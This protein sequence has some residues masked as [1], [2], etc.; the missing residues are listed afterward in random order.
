MDKKLL[1]DNY[2]TEGKT[3]IKRLDKAGFPVT[4][5]FWFFDTGSDDWKLILATPYYDT[6]GPHDTYQEISKYMKKIEEI[7]LKNIQTLSPNNQLISLLKSVLITE[8]NAI[9]GIRF[10]GNTINNIFIPDAYIYR[11]S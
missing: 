9:M 5:A 7:S 10:T 11:L 4:S 6:K 2:I 1:V 8:K 3:L